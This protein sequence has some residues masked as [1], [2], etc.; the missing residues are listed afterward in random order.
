MAALAALGGVSGSAVSWVGKALHTV[1]GIPGGL[2][3]LAGVHVLWLVLAVG[4]I[5]KPGAATL[6]GL[7]KGAVELLTGNPHGLLVLLMSGLGGIAVD[8]VWLIVGR[9]D[10]LVTYL[11]AGG[12]GAAS[13]LLVFKV[14]YSL[15]TSRAVNIGLAALTGVAFVSGAVLAGLLGWSLMD[16]LRRAGVV[17]TQR[18]A[19]AR[20]PGLRTWMSLGVVAVVVLFAG[21]AFFYSSIQG[22]VQAK[23]RTA[24]VTTPS[25]G[26]GSS[27]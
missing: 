14:I 12:L 4:L 19:R 15:P 16:A 18:P 17:G 21:I 22:E 5:G 1:T 8:L 27:R 3:F 20:P 23:S 25:P 24:A 11:L 2:Q 26:P 6:T 10:R 7:L 13:N 9:R